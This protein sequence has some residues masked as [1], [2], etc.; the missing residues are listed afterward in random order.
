M[1]KYNI[2]N[3]KEYDTVENYVLI[4]SSDRNGIHYICKYKKGICV[5]SLLIDPT[6]TIVTSNIER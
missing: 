1:I 6:A 5:P 2:R 4:L 3:N